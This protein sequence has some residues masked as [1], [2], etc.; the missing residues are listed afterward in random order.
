MVWPLPFPMSDATPSRNDRVLARRVGEAVFLLDP[1][2]GEYFT[3]D[4]VGGRIWELCD[5][6]KTIAQIAQTLAIEFDAPFEQIE[7]DA[8]DLL[9]EL[10]SSRLVA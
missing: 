3:L 5:G 7:A 6:T 9:S 10:A 8:S 4:D 2:S 1:D